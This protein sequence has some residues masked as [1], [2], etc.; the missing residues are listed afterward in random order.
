LRKVYKIIDLHSKS[1]LT[2]DSL[3]TQYITFEKA[4]SDPCAKILDVCPLLAPY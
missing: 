1:D 2:K 3:G 4:Y